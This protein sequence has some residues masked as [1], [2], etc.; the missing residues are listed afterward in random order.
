MPNDLWIIA[1]PLIVQ[2]SSGSIHAL[3]IFKAWLKDGNM[4]W[5]CAWNIYLAYGLT[6]LEQGSGPIGSITQ[7][8][9]S[10][11]VWNCWQGLRLCVLLMLPVITS[12]HHLLYI[13]KKFLLQDPHVW[14][15]TILGNV[16]DLEPRA[17][18]PLC[19]WSRP[20]LCTKFRDKDNQSFKPS[21]NYSQAALCPLFLFNNMFYYLK[22]INSYHRWIIIESCEIYRFKSAAGC[23]INLMPFSSMWVGRL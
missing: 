20:G 8:T 14:R 10:R 15:K 2:S 4:A 1:N 21:E 23:I 3:F 7:C 9:G 11:S 5:R 17:F 16:D 19:F 18:V 6:A 12:V 22:I 13:W